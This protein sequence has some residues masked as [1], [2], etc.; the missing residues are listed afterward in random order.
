MGAWIVDGR[1]VDPAEACH[2]SVKGP[3]VD[4]RLGVDADWDGSH[5]DAPTDGVS[6]MIAGNYGLAGAMAA[7]AVAADEP[8]PLDMVPP[9]YIAQR[10]AAIGAR[11][12]RWNGASVDWD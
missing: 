4:G 3:M 2:L 6:M 10:W 9:R 12:G 1:E 5:W 7:Q 8:G 11:V